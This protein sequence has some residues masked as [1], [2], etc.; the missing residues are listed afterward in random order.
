[1]IGTGATAT[2]TM[3]DYFVMG[4]NMKAII[5]GPTNQ[6]ALIA[7]IVPGGTGS[8]PQTPYLML[9]QNF[10]NRWQVSNGI[11]YDETLGEIG[12][13]GE[14][15]WVVGLTDTNGFNAYIDIFS[16]TN[17]S[18]IYTQTTFPSDGQ[19]TMQTTRADGARFTIFDGLAT[20]LTVL[21]PYMAD[22]TSP[23]QLDTK[24]THTTGNLISVLNHSTNK[25]N[26]TFNGVANAVGGFSSI[27]TDTGAIS[28]TGWTNSL[29]KDADVAFDATTLIYKLADNAGAWWYTNSVAVGQGFIH[30]QPGGK[31]VLVS[32]SGLTGQYHA[33]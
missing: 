21:Q 8:L 5:Q 1:M 27:A 29:G 2:T 6:T 10:T 26:I 14:S 4:P 24:L 22:G 18:T 20:Y 19:A 3:Q 16:S 23:Y 31:F 13:Y 9:G 15:E 33:H 11:W 30:L 32:G 28:T 12:Q 17:E 25:F 7:G